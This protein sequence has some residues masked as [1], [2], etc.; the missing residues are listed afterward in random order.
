MDSDSFSVIKVWVLEKDDVTLAM[1]LK[2]F[3][4]PGKEMRVSLATSVAI[5]LLGFSTR[6]LLLFLEKERNNESI[7]WLE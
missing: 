5:I 7:V 1:V 2:V 6:K 4:Q 3:L